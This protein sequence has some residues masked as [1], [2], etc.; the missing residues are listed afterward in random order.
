[1]RVVLAAPENPKKHLKYKAILWF[2]NG[3][4]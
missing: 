2:N 4:F 1:V 3:L